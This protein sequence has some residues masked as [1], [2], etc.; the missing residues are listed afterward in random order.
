ML[1]STIHALHL[2]AIVCWFAGLFYLP[3]LYVYHA[4]NQNKDQCTEMLK[5]MERR[6]YRGIMI[7][8]M[9]A[10]WGLGLYLIHLNPAWMQQGWLH[11]KLSLVVVLTIYHFS[12]G[13]YRKKF[14]AEENRRTGR[15][16]RMY[17]E[18]PTIFLIAIVLLAVIKPF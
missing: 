15:F 5:V 3:R 10:T 18:V 13:H 2:I 12:L 6:L 7:P 4:E 16:F 17:N 8:A 11:T 1:Y 14:A 9:L